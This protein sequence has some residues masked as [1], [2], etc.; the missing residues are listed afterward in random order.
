MKRKEI[1]TLFFIMEQRYANSE[2]Q[3]TKDL[4]TVY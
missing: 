2:S 3:E 1:L 4:L